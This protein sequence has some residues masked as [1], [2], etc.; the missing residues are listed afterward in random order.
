MKI[1]FY[2]EPHPI[3]NE[4][5]HHR[6]ILLGKW[7]KKVLNWANNNQ[8]GD[9]EVRIACHQL[10]YQDVQKHLPNLTPYLM[11]T[12]FAEETQ[13][14][15]NLVL[16]G[17]HGVSLWE[18]LM[19]GEENE[20]LSVYLN[21]IERIKGDFDF[22]VVVFWGIN[23]LV[24]KKVN[25]LGARSIFMELASIRNPFPASIY[26]D[27]DGV[28]G[29][30]S[31]R[32][33]SK[34]YIDSKSQLLKS[35]QQ[36]LDGKIKNVLT[37][38]TLFDKK[39]DFSPVNFTTSPKIVSKGTIL[40][41]LQI[42]D[43][44]NILLGS[45]YSNVCAFVADVLE[46]FKDKDYT[47]VFKPHPG[48]KSRGGVVFNDHYAAKQLVECEDNCFWYEEEVPKENYLSFIRQ[49][50][51][52]ITINSSLGFEAMILGVPVFA[53]GEAIYFTHDYPLNKNDIPNILESENEIKMRVD[54]GYKISDFIMNYVFMSEEVFDSNLEFLVKKMNIYTDDTLTSTEDMYNS[55][56]SN[57]LVMWG[58]D[59]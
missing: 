4:L 51:A 35:S 31:V 29:F 15:Q 32:R 43:D 18:N 53:L 9:H 16:W 58:E 52:V 5:T 57:N 55:L 7:G 46:I 49:F 45:E 47:L 50:S 26:A 36:L 10:A 37:S 20:K 33:L 12:N 11:P 42:G 21:Y 3:R 59:V 24:S 25:E 22:D 27:S 14:H 54:F 17:T 48:A 6:A 44:S 23:G 2:V 39:F 56:I 41:P 19:R 38:P 13:I 28:N 8:L 40:V 1:L 30:S 34:D